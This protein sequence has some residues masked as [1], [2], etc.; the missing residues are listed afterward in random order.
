MWLVVAFVIWRLGFWRCSFDVG[1]LSLVLSFSRWA[2]AFGF[3]RLAFVVGLLP[4]VR[5][6][7]LGMFGV[8]GRGAEEQRRDVRVTL[9]FW[10]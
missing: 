3:C 2:A 6:F 1:L 9:G 10:R 7:A 5:L 4:G 8:A